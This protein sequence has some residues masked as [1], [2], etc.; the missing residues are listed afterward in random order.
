MNEVQ[1]YDYSRRSGV[2][3]ISWTQVIEMARSLAEQLADRQ[4]D[5]VVGIARAGLLP[6]T[7]IACSLRLDLFPVRVTRR[8]KDQVV[9]RSPQWIM[10]LP[11]QGIGQRVAVVDE[12]A[13]TGETLALVAERVRSAGARQVYTATLVSHTW[14]NPRPDLCELVT[15]AL[16]IFPWDDPV[17][18]NGVWQ[19]HPELR[20]ALDEL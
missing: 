15:D 1:P 2:E 3:R 7:L 4:V 10:D 13:A 16:C 14:A 11:A 9:R 19:L 17:Y 6:A 20:K 8:E 12:I 5:S 18:Q